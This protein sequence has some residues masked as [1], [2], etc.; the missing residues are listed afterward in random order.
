MKIIERLQNYIDYKR[1]SYNSF[2]KSIGASNGYIG[3]Q[4]KNGASIGGDVIEKISCI[5]SDLSIEWL[6]TGKGN[7]IKILELEESNIKSFSNSS[8]DLMLLIK[9]KD[10]EIKEMSQEIGRLKEQVE[11]LK[12]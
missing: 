7:M 12:K 3:K 9:E 10:K 5:Y 2:D 11:M 1:I 6:I 8:P 4:I